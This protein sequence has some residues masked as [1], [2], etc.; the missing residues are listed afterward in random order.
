MVGDEEKERVWVRVYVYCVFSFVWVRVYVYFV[1]SFV[2]VR[3]SV[4]MS[5]GLGGG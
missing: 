1:F 3:V 4:G 5:G 2:W